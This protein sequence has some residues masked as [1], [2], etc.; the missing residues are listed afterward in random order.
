LGTESLMRTVARLNTSVE[1]LAALGAELHLRQKGADGDPRVR[2]ILQQIVQHLDPMLLDGADVNQMAAVFGGIQSYFRQAI[3]LVENPTRPPGWAFDPTVLQAQG[4]LSWVV[5]HE[6]DNLGA[7]RPD[8]EKTLRGPGAFLDVGTGVG[9]LAIEAAHVWSAMKV[10]GIDPWETALN[11]AREN[12]A[13]SDVAERIELRAQGVEQ[14]DDRD[15]FTLAW[16]PGVFLSHDIVADALQRTR[17]ALKPSGWLVFGLYASPPD[18]LGEA[19]TAL[20]T[21]RSGGHPW[22]PVQ[23]EDCLRQLGFEQIETVKTNSPVA[24]VIGR[25]PT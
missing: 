1:A 22:L 5:V 3:D 24:V 10:V 17:Q 7:T 20:R 15:A 18:P 13:S 19:L 23:I 11:L 9:W 6:I 2:A 12:V 25:R 4:R 16:M 21:V 8:L 14:L